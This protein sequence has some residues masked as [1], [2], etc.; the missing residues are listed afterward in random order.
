MSL[1][2]KT[3]RLMHSSMRGPT[4]EEAERRLD[5]REQS[6]EKRGCLAA[7]LQL[8]GSREYGILRR[9][10]R[11]GDLSGPGCL[12]WD[13]QRVRENRKSDVETLGCTNI[14]EYTPENIKT[15]L[16]FLGLVAMETTGT[17]VADGLGI[18][19]QSMDALTAS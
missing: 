7:D 8:S 11:S 12:N 6:P 10:R 13:G 9:L 15:G 14:Q 2:K 17:D 5:W 1:Q 16:T 4:L 19:E 3:C 18:N